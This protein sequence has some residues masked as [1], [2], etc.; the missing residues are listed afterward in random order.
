MAQTDVLGT[1]PGSQL[2]MA[3]LA[4]VLHGTV[5]PPSCCLLPAIISQAP[6][7][8]QP[9]LESCSRDVLGNHLFFGDFFAEKVP[10]RGARME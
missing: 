7:A 9:R 1:P 2:R 8:R 3:G 5:E 4:L 6:S 10:S